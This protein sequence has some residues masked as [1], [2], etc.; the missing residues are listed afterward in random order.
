MSNCL[1]SLSGELKKSDAVQHALALRSAWVL[2]NYHSFF[3][4]YLTAP[5]MS[6]Y[7]I[8]LFAERVRKQA[9]K[10]MFKSWVEVYLL[11]FSI[12]LYKCSGLDT[13]CDFRPRHL[14]Y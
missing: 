9:L 2:C 13:F 8:D 6:G 14:V 4:L 3:Q 1:V 5:N 10:I 7:L 12:Y 11:S